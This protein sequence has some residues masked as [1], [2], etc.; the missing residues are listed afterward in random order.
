MPRDGIGMIEGEAMRHA[1]AAVVPYDGEAVEAEVAH[2]LHF[3]LRHGALGVVDVL[4]AV[5]RLAAVPV[6]AQVWRDD[7]AFLRKLGRDAIPG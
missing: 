7:G 1:S 6:T 5:F 2:Q 4:I 3:V